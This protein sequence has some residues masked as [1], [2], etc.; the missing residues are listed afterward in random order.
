MCR[1]AV[2]VDDFFNFLTPFSFLCLVIISFWNFAIF[3]S[4]FSVISLAGFILRILC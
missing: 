3:S 4:L 2:L 1:G